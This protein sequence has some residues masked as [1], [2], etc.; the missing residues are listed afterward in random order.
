MNQDFSLAGRWKALPCFLFNVA[1]YSIFAAL[2][3]STFAQEKGTDGSAESQANEVVAVVDGFSIRRQAILNRTPK[4]NGLALTEQQRKEIDDAIL[5]RVID[6]HIVHRYLESFDKVVSESE[7]TLQLETFEAELAKYEKSLE[8]HLA[9]KH[10]TV[11]EFK[12][13]FSMQ[14]SWKAYLREK[15]TDENL[16]IHYDR[17]RR[18]FDGSDVRVA[19]LFIAIDEDLEGSRTQ[20]NEI[21]SALQ[22]GKIPWSEAVKNHSQGSKRNEGE[23]GLVVKGSAM[24]P[25]FTSAALA[26]EVG[27]ISQPVETQLGIHIIKCLEVVPGTVGLRDAEK[28]VLDDAERFLFRT[29]V[30]RHRDKVKIEIKE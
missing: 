18:K 19:H 25:K 16:A 27:Q 11:E 21:H 2:P 12:Q 8:D 22:Q 3:G 30:E 28:A 26:L 5:Q 23:I 14:L 24:P 17:N 20:A 4:L 15:L 29:I 9:E 13:D 1:I 10:Q 7:L 6:A